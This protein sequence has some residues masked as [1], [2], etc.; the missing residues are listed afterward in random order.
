[1]DHFNYQNGQLLCD[2]VPVQAIA[3]SVGTPVY[4]YSKA[5]LLEHYTRI[6][7]AFAPLKPLICYSVKSCPNLGVCR[8]LVQAGAGM[9]VVSGGEIHRALA[10]GAAP[11]HIVYAG[12][13]KSDDE[14]RMA[15]RTGVGLL[16]VESEA[17][18]ENIRRIAQE[19]GA[20]CRAA[21]RVNPDVD[22]RTHR[23]TS[24]GNKE[25]KFGV[26][27]ER[28]VAFFRAYGRDPHVRLCGLHLHLGSPIYTTDPYRSGITKALALRDQLL[29]EGFTVDVLDIGG[30]FA[31]DY[32]TG[33]S[34]SAAQ[35]AEVIV[36]L[37]LPLV[38]AGVRIVLEPGRSIAANA[39]ILLTR[40]AYMKRSGD[41]TFAICDAGMN[42]LLRPSHYEAF[43]FMWPAH[44]KTG[45]VPTVRTEKPD[46]PGL[47][48][49]D[50]VGPLCET[51]D[52]LALDRSLPPMERGDLLA[53]FTA[54]AYGMSMASRYNSAPLPAEVLVDGDRFAV[55][56][57]RE[58]YADLVAH[59]LQAS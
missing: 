24:T 38:Q 57:R 27:I 12:V 35:Y 45:F 7:N 50:V 59:E 31:A 11:E 47:I 56:R 55:V 23:Y 36:P 44:P 9:D 1:M 15:M 13:G 33:R 19:L 41:K 3:D 53:I 52:F 37:L 14:L 58:T 10:A 48:T 32:Q 25:T 4:I 18:F 43:H 5:T 30:G 54:G 34:P 39:G 2:R 29:K 46:M 17:E 28:A 21:L 22:P 16:N 8:T 40:I 51:G 42:A 6:H 20:Q 26:D 49:M